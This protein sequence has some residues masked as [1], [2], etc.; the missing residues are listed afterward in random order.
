ML[1]AH[2]LEVQYAAQRRLGPAS[3]ELRPGSLHALVGPNGA[4]KTTL[5]RVLS[6]EL[7]P[8]SGTLE[9]DGRPMARWSWAELARRR[10]VLPQSASLQFAFTVAEVLSLGLTDTLTARQAETR[11]QRLLGHCG[12]EAL[13]TRRYTELSGGE[14]ARVQLARVLAQV[15][16]GSEAAVAQPRYLLLDEPLASQDPAYRATLG[17]VLRGCAQ[18]GF[19]VLLSLHDLNL[20]ARLCDDI[21]VLAAGVTVAQGRPEHVLASAATQQAYGMALRWDLTS[22]GD[23]VLQA[24][25]LGPV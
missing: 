7:P 6:G 11:I 17:A 24:P 22:A 25:G 12:I 5:L 9:L 20:A 4:G 10:A 8:S 18:R 2:E 16:D 23:Q 19:G 1:Y 21:T 3:L 15:W 14:Q 13:A